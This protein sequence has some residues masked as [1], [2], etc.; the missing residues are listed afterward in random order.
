MT[1]GS[2][3]YS[4]TTDPSR[5]QDATVA[6]GWIA[7]SSLLFAFLQSVCTLLAAM[8]GL[9]LAIGI[10]SIAL[11]ADAGTLTR[12]NSCRLA[13]NSNDQPGDYGIVA[14]SHCNLAFE[15]PAQTA[16]FSLAPDADK[17]SARA[18]GEASDDSIL[19]CIGAHCR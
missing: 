11:S 5:S 14:E 1:S 2:P 6:R 3:Q 8:V 16:C 10:G 13:S 12:P 15:A 4:E 18:D 9:R 7:W 19:G 17:R